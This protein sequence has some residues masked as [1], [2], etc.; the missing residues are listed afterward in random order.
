[1]DVV[2]FQELFSATVLFFIIRFF[3]SKL[4]KPHPP[5]PPGPKGWPVLGCLPLLGSMPHAS[6]AELARRHGPIMHLKMGTCDVVVASSPDAAMAFLKTLDHSFSNRPPGAGPTYIAYNAMDMV[7]ADVGPRWKLLRKLAN[8]HMLGAKD[9]GDWS[10]LRH[11][12]VGLMVRDIY[13]L[14]QQWKPVP[15]LELVSCALANI[16][17]QKSISRRVFTAHG[18]ESNDFKSM[19]V[20]LMRLA[21]LFNIGDFIPAIEWMD[22]QGIQGKMKRLHNKFDALL[23]K[24]LEEHMKTA[25]ERKGSSDFFD[26]VMGIKEDDGVA[27]TM[28]NYKALLLN[29]FIA[30]TDTSSSTIEWAMAEMLKNPSILNLVQAEIDTVVGKNR[31]LKESD[32]PK[33][34]YLQAICKE[35]FRKHPVVPLSLPRVTSEPCEVNGYYIPKNTR[36]FVNVWAIGRDPELWENPHEFNPERFL[37]GKNANIEPR[38]NDFELIPFGSGRRICAGIRMGIAIVQ[39]VVG[40]L[41]HSFDWKLSDGVEIEMEAAFGLVLGK[42]EKLKAMAI[43]RLEPNAYEDSS[44]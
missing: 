26:I 34:P 11:K 24:M 28:T 14:S 33:L 44:S 7:F 39:Y 42:A 35:T 8:L 15:V 22:L 17:G 29:L 1:M 21:G 4:L 38:G 6:L 10:P 36:L 20:E 18:E 43:P 37:S 13:E 40:T 3:I 9:F 5:L 19:I 41:V 32:I 25:H 31:R 23:T 27:L 30:G 2:H 16:I 12:E